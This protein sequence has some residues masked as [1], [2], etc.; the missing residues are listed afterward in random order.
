LPAILALLIR[1]GNYITHETDWNI[2]PSDIDNADWFAF[3]GSYLGGIA[4][5]VAVWWTVDKTENH[6]KLTTNEQTRQNEEIRQERERQRKL[7]ILPVILLQPRMLIPPS[8]KGDHNTHRR[9]RAD[10]ERV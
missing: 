3:W 4:T 9:F 5:V 10:L 2:N 1:A 8:A 7:D 6:F